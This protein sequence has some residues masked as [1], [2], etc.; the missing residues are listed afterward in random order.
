MDYI[1]PTRPPHRQ[2]L[3]QSE[4][5]TRLLGSRLCCRS[6]LCPLPSASL[7][8][9]AHIFSNTPL[10][11]HC[12][13]RCVNSWTLRLFSSPSCS[14]TSAR[15]ITRKTRVKKRKDFPF[16]LERKMP[17]LLSLAVP[18]LLSFRNRLTAC[19]SRWPCSPKREEKR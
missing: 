16:L 15:T 9:S 12:A 13:L 10:F 5:L 19:R 14:K 6:L 4:A 3:Q 2:L 8:Q 11:L 1:S 18:A 17:R 7:A